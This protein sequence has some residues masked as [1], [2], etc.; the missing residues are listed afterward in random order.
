MLYLDYLPSDVEAPTFSDCPSSVVIDPLTSPDFTIPTADDNNAID[1]LDVTPA[2]F[3]PSDI[4]A[5]NLQVTYTAT[6]FYDKQ[7]FCPI[8]IRIR[9][10]CEWWKTLYNTQ[11]LDELV[12]LNQRLSVYSSA[13]VTPHSSYTV[14]HHNPADR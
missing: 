10:R 13:L 7:Q 14:G 5:E 1:T 12:P 3:L 9:G 2:N 11:T 6:D 8:A 4:L